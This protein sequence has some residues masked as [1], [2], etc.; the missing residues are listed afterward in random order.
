MRGEWKTWK[1]PFYFVILFV[2]LHKICDV[3]AVEVSTLWIYVLVWT[4]LLFQNSRRVYA[5]I[6]PF[7]ASKPLMTV[8]TKLL[9]VASPDF[10]KTDTTPDSNNT[11]KQP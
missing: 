1:Y 7:A 9:K 3:L 11:P 4:A 10:G 8:A 5:S 2:A 6:E